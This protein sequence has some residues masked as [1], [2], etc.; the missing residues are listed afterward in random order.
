MRF[1][2]AAVSCCIT[3]GRVAERLRDLAGQGAGRAA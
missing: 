1:L 3:A 2:C